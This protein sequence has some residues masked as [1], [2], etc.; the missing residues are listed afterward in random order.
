MDAVTQL[1]QKRVQYAFE[2]CCA[3]PLSEEN[4]DCVRHGYRSLT[5]RLAILALPE[6]VCAHALV[7][8]TSAQVHAL[9]FVRRTLVAT[10]QEEAADGYSGIE[11]MEKFVERL[12]QLI[13]QIEKR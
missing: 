2:K 1:G 5:S 3:V 13:A 10:A 6:E 4:P 12:N 11:V 8:E 9:E 7:V